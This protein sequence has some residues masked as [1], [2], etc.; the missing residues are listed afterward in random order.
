[1]AGWMSLGGFSW[2]I[3]RRE[4]RQEGPRGTWREAERRHWRSH[5]ERE[6]CLS[7]S[8]IQAGNPLSFREAHDPTKG[9]S[10]SNVDASARDY[11][12]GPLR[13]H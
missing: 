2:P 3:P 13:A 8:D 10:F 6:R 1:V 12:A 9:V 11:V 5:S 7:G 4:I